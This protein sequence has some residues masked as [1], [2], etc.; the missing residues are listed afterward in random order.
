MIPITQ[1]PVQPPAERSTSRWR[2][3]CS[4]PLLGA[5]VIVR[6]NP[7]PRTLLPHRFPPPSCWWRTPTVRRTL[8]LFSTLRKGTDER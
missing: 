4:R 7:S 3:R 8:V 6:D 5:R 2:R 1:L